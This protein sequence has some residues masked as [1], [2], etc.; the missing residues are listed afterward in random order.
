[1]KNY[2]K[3]QEKSKNLEKILKYKIHK[4]VQ[5]YLKKIRKNL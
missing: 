1:M 4:K 5:K 2:N 3:K